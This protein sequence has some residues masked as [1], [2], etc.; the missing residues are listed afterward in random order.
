MCE[1]LNSIYRTASTMETSYETLR[2]SKPADFVCQVE[3]NRPDKRNAMNP[4]FWRYNVLR[5]DTSVI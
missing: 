1:A 5:M 2:L 3:L 4:T